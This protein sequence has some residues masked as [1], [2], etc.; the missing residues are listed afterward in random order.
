MTAPR[1]IPDPLDG[2]GCLGA[3]IGVLLT[4][5]LTAL[6]FFAVFLVGRT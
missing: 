3:F 6:V 5:A 2:N 1:P 4:V